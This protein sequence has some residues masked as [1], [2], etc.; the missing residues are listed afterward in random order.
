MSKWCYGLQLIFQKVIRPKTKGTFYRWPV[1]DQGLRMLLK[2]YT[3][4]NCIQN[5]EALF[6][7]T[8]SYDLIFLTRFGFNVM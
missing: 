6:S 1:I 7:S 5:R 2:L 3:E 8:R 4:E